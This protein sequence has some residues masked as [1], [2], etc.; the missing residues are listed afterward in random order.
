MDSVNYFPRP[1][2][3]LPHVK[4]DVNLFTVAMRNLFDNAVAAMHGRGVLK[5]S[6]YLVQNLNETR[7]YLTLSD[8]G[9]GIAA[10]DIPK[11]FQPYFST[12]ERGTGLGLIITKKIV[13]DHGG[14][15]SFTT[16]A[17][18]GT[19]FIVQLPVSVGENGR[20]NAS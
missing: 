14:S 7:A 1:A 17:G 10:E 16:R 6:T 2:S 12:M 18:L 13:E 15:I 19:E 8:T 20:T 4:L 11:V 5:V 9:C 3:D